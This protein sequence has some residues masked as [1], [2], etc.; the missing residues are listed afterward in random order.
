MVIS[1][2]VWDTWE[3]EKE[4]GRENKR[5]EERKKER[6]REKKGNYCLPT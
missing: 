5:E 6:E 1:R 2:P 4:G 3:G